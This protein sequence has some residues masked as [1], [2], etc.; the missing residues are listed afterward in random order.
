MKLSEAFKYLASHALGGRAAYVFAVMA[1][2][3]SNAAP[4]KIAAAGG[5][6]IFHVAMLVTTVY[7]EWKQDRIIGVDLHRAR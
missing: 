1:I 6:V 7:A 3:F 2:L 5:F 4:M